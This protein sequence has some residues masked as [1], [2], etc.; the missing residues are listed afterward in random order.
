MERR[1]FLKD[2]GRLISGAA[3]V[4]IFGTLGHTQNAGPDGTCNPPGCGDGNGG[5]W[6]HLNGPVHTSNANRA[7]S[8]MTLFKQGGLT[9]SY[10]SATVSSYSVPA[11]NN[12]QLYGYT[13]ELRTLCLQQIS[14]NGGNYGPL[15]QSQINTVVA[16]AAAYGY[17]VTAAETSA[18]N[19]FFSIS[20]VLAA[21]AATPATAP[22]STLMP[23]SG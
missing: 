14:Q 1:Q 20:T 10:A 6:Q 9:N 4:G 19:S 11:I 8:Q 5:Y 2:T 23:V 3:A 18:I 12:L 16:K 22:A 13:E 15:T 21:A 7:G 17:T